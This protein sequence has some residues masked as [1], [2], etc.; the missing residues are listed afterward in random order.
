MVNPNNDSKKKEHIE[1]TENT[2][3]T[4]LTLAILGVFGIIII[5]C[6]Y[7]FMKTRHPKTF[8]KVLSGVSSS[9]TSS[10]VPLTATPPAYK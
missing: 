3:N 6:I 8:N 5:A 4:F 2:M 9:I 10:M 7:Y 1:N